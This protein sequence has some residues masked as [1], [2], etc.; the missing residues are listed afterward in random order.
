MWNCLKQTDKAENIN[1]TKTKTIISGY[2]GKMKHG[3]IKLGIKVRFFF[4]YVYAF[5]FP[6]FL[7][8]HL[9]KQNRNVLIFFIHFIYR[10]FILSYII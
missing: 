2:S 8:W 9:K 10:S 4:M 1:K 6:I 7:I 5:E 3:F